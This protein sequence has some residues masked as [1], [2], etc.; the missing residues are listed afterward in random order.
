MDTVAEILKGQDCYLSGP[1]EQCNAKENW[2]IPVI[3]TLTERYGLKV[4]DP[5]AD[6]KQQWADD[7]KKARAEK[8]YK[9]MARIAKKFVRKDLQVVQRSDLV[10]AYLPFGVPTCGTHHEIFLSNM[11]KNP[12]LLVCPQGKEFNPLWY[13]GFIPEEHM[14]GNWED[15]YAY[16]DEVHSG[17][18]KYNYRW[19]FIYNVL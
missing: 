1:I 17:Q 9:T 14:F 16:L 5:H 11:L 19:D 13:F 4:F 12:T 7:L 10:I 6:P 18:S 3:K 2:R 8:D 15:L